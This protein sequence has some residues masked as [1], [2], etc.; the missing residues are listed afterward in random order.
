[1]TGGTSS[2][3]VPKTELERKSSLRDKFRGLS[4]SKKGEKGSN[5]LK[6][7]NSPQQ[8][9]EDPKTGFVISP[10]ESRGRS[11][12]RLDY[13]SEYFDSNT[14]SKRNSIAIPESSMD[15]VVLASAATDSTI[16]DLPVL[17][18]AIS[19]R[20][21]E[22]FPK[23]SESSD[24][25]EE[26][27]QEGYLLQPSGFLSSVFSAATNFGTALTMGASKQ[28]RPPVLSL[29]NDNP[30][31]S[32]SST[33]RKDILNSVK[34]AGHSRTGHELSL[35]DMGI[36]GPDEYAS[37]S[38]VP[39][40]RTEP[41]SSKNDISEAKDAFDDKKV[42]N[43]RSGSV[44][45]TRNRKRRGS[46]ATSIFGSAE[47]Q[48]QKITGFAVASNKRNREFHATFRSVP[49]ADYLLDGKIH[50]LHGKVEYSDD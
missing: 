39:P 50:D 2:L 49:D 16:D 6:D 14:G 5:S 32:T 19:S 1:M 40:S 13:E 17:A 18:P 47:T 46:T 26:V 37:S 3:D 42:L 10:Q 12:T 28:V 8:T 35:K 25:T 23:S 33:P 41:D 43:A 45:T 34:T 9:L 20:V 22:T 48:S 7:S 30:D 24:H 36:I 27:P 15:D 29:I 4:R 31:G 44:S 21:E 11:V 38:P